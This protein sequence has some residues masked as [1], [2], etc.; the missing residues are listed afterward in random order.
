[1]PKD[2]T[3][4]IKLSELGGK[5]MTPA[6]QRAME[7]EINQQCLEHDERLSLDIDTVVLWTLHQHLGFGKKRLHDFYIAMT[8][9]HRRMRECYQTDDL[10]PER[11]KLRELGVDVEQW[12]KE[13][14]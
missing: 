2:P 7:H 5:M 3:I 13:I 6:M 12:Q 4:N 14:Q 10:Y 1:M 11:Y 8:A 9:E